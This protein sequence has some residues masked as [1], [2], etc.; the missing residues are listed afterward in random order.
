MVRS[1]RIYPKEEIATRLARV[2]R[3]RLAVLPTPL[4]DCPR[5][6]EALGG[7]RILVKRDDLTGLA[8]GGNKTRRLEFFMGEAQQQGADLIIAGASLQSNH[9]RQTA[10][11][12]NKLGMKTVLILWGKVEGELQGNLLLDDILGADIFAVEG[13][14]FQ[15]IR[16][17]FY[18]KEEEYR[19]KGYTPCVLDTFGPSGRFGVLGYVDCALE[20]STQL[21]EQDVAP[22]YVVTAVGTGGTHAGL[23]L[24]ATLLGASHKVYGIS[25]RRSK[26]DILAFETKESR[27]AA[28]ALDLDVSLAPEDILVN[29]AHRGPA[30]GVVTQQEI[31]A[32]R[33]AAQT[34]AL[35]LDPTYTGKAMAGLIDLVRE[36]AFGPQDTIVFLHTGGTPIIFARNQALASGANV[37]TI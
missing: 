9:C 34:E 16:P 22:S 4:Q 8:F 17:I 19:N 32:I 24:G 33:L 18:E 15:S 14:D 2:P 1:S 30:Y 20:L 3:A 23:A 10:A 26:G 12:A 37:R 36:G 28:E 6:S 21:E 11:A 31:E 35:I 27:E 5:L 7:P 13:A 29:D 25:V